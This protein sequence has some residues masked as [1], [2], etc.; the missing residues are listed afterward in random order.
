V[1]A[2]QRALEN[3]GARVVLTVV[4]GTISV[5]ALIRLD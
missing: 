5:A 1:Q 3:G 4:I 2:F